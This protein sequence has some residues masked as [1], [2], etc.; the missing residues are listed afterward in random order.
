MII[1]VNWC[2]TWKLMFNDN[3]ESNTITESNNSSSV[4]IVEDKF[5]EGISKFEWS[6]FRYKLL[7]FDFFGC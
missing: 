4:A 1:L 5:Q 3:L 2:D 6:P 7:D